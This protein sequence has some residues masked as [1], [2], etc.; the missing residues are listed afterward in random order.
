MRAKCACFACFLGI[1]I[2]NEHFQHQNR[3]V[4]KFSWIFSPCGS[5]SENAIKSIMVWSLRVFQFCTHT[6]TYLYSTCWSDIL[7]S[8]F[9]VC[10]C[11]ILR[12]LHMPMSMPIFFLQFFFS[13]S[14]ENCCVLPLRLFISL[15]VL[16]ISSIW[17]VYTC[18]Q[19][20]YMYL[21]ISLSRQPQ[22]NY[23]LYDCILSEPTHRS[24]CTNASTTRII[25]I[26]FFVHFFKIAHNRIVKKNL[27]W[28]N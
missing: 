9:L 26:F 1:H 16:L 17:C 4:S 24:Y 15:C 23:T 25:F 19:C 21:R 8:H 5:A 14:L 20:H 27:R 18:Q 10:V 2:P 6:N 13:L 12:Q 7:C 28:T 3:F 11:V 22:C